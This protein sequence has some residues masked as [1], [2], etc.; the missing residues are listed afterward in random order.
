MTSPDTEFISILGASSGGGDASRSK[1]S[2]K[3]LPDVLPVLGLSDI[4]VF[5]GMAAPLLVDSAQSIRLIDD[6]VAGNRFLCLVLQRRPDVEN[7]LPQDLWP[8]G[9]AARISKMLKYPDHTVRVLVEGLRRV[10][11]K[12]YESQDPYLRAKIEVLKDITEDTIEMTA[13]TRS[14]QQR[15]QEI[16]NLSPTLTEQVKIAAINTPD[17]G[18]LSDLITANLNLSLDERQQLLEINVVRDRLTRLLPLLSREL[19]VVTLGS[20]IQNEVASSMSKNQR[21]F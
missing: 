13:L 3:S 8:H 12:E 17:P 15:F 21:D 11:I 2:S 10:Q 4:V 19:E 1:L 16:I 18:K 14:T 9:C 20:K 7:P 5:P 6:V